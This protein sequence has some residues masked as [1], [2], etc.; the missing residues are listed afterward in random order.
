[1]R[2]NS[3]IGNPLLL[4][5]L[6]AAGVL[7]TEVWITGTNGFSA[8]P[9]V[10]ALAVTA[11][12]VVGIPLAYY[13]LVVRRK[14]LP[15]ITVAPVFVL[16]LIMAGRILPAEQHTYLNYAE[17]VVPLVEL[18]VLAFIALNL[19]K[20]ASH[21][22]RL[23]PNHAYFPETLEAS[24]RTALPAFPPLVV[25]LLTTEVSLVS[26]G[27]TGWL[28]RARPATDGLPRFS[29][30][31]VGSYPVILGFLAFIMVLETSVLH[32]VVMHWSPAV[33][34]VLTIASVYTLIWFFGDF[35]AS[36]LQPIVAGDT[37]LHIR[38]GMR[39]RAD[40]PW[41]QIEAVC[42]ATSADRKQ[43]DFL[44]AA[45]MGE[46]RLVIV[47]REPV[48]VHGLL[49]RTRQT[50]HIGFSVDDEARFLNIANAR[51]AAVIAD[52]I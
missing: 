45:I 3:R 22:R 26:F 33:A 11:D 43:P 2:T 4:W 37:R 52:Q 8:Q 12:I 47:L 21:Y 49:G 10:V 5:A 36:R 48:T 15:V 13:L 17:L 31:R 23:R 46:A 24:L 28:R 42:K 25:N 50:A 29:Y 44:N 51:L 1:M 40:I 41:W 27:L 18:S 7:A 35:H 9:D 34:W 32:L 6:L 19:R 20:V 30:H 14:G 39:W 38:S 16:S